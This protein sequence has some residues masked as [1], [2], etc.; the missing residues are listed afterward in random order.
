MEI[1]VII[2]THNRAS[3]LEKSL[4]KIFSSNFP[5]NK[6]EVI[7]IDDGST[8]NTDLICKSIKEKNFKY[9]KQKKAGQGVAR[10]KG[11]E[12]AQGKIILFGQDDIFITKNFLLEHYNF[13]QKNPKKNYACLGLILWDPELEVNEIMKWNTNEI[14]LFGKFG[15]HQFAYNQLKDKKQANYNYFYT[16]NL[17]LKKEIFINNKFDPWFDGYGWEDIE[18]GYRLTKKENLK[19]FYNSQAVVYHHHPMNL[20]DFKQRMIQI[21][22]AIHLFKQ[23]HPEVNVFPSSKKIIIFKIITSKI[24]IFIIKNINKIFN[25][26]FIAVYLYCISKKYFLIGFNNI[27][28]K[29]KNENQ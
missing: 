16:S 18:L 15:G 6:Y 8:D 29:L 28:N 21:G 19:L 14:T 1:S 22:S 26:Y 7:V 13:H 27:P 11:I 12:I 20:E 17:S 25:N 2:P 24:F 3:L 10:N 23:K 4:S 5:K 9:I